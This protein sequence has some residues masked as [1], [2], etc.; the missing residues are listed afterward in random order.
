MLESFGMKVS[1]D[2]AGLWLWPLA[3]LYV[4]RIVKGADPRWWLAAGACI[5]VAL[6]SKYS[7]IF[8]AIALALGLALT[9][10]R[11]AM[12]TPWFL[13]GAAVAVALAI[14]NFI[15][16]ALHGFP[17]WELLQNGAHGKNVIAPWWLFLFQQ[18][19]LT[20]LFVAPIWIA[21]LIRLLYGSATRFLGY[22]FVLLIAMM[23]A[24]HAKHYYPADVY[25]VLMAAGGVAFEG[26]T[27]RARFV[28]PLLVAATVAAGL[29]FLPFSLPLLAEPA[30][31]GYS[32]FVSNALGIGRSTM[33]TERMRS[34]ALPEDF[35][36]MHGWPQLVQSVAAIYDALPPASARRRRSSRATMERLLRSTSSAAVTACRPPSPAT[37]TIGSGAGAT[38]AEASSSTSTATAAAPISPGSSAVCGSSPIPTRRG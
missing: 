28:R 9:P 11:R 34:S 30:M 8:F 38:T 37:T 16:Q 18:L 29:F 35:A 5:G 17:M 4:L 2:M 36:D 20:N 7:V 32:G 23:I 21:G 12:R 19:L 10:Q 33:A 26:L 13:A 15:W 22:A 3:A 6:E 25:P 24:L 31:L 27:A 1:P 14:P